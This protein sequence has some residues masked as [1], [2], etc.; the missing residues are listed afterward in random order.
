MRT[1]GKVGGICSAGRFFILSLD[2]CLGS[3]LAAQPCAHRAGRIDSGGRKRRG[4][5][6]D[7]GPNHLVWQRQARR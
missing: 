7:C 2:I 4:R 5:E 6:A 3:G 1:L